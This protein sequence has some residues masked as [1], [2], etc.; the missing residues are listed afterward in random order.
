M[1]SLRVGAIVTA[2][3]AGLQSVAAAAQTINPGPFTEAQT[4]TGRQGYRT[5]CASCH[6]D[7]LSGKGAPAL[8]GKEF[9]AS[10]I[11]QLTTA[12]LYAYIQSTM[13]YDQS[14]SL[15]SE[16]Y[17][18]I[19]AFILEANGAKPGDQTLTPATSVKVGDIITG[20][21]PTNFVHDAETK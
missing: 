17:L 13:P 5:Y 15:T 7:D 19:L 1:N 16:M 9:A 8:A 3:T 20:I 4:V 11:G 21:P 10:Q 18:N 6:G 14:G 12:Q 2:M